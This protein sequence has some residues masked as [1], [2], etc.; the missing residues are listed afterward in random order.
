MI[1]R[2]LEA[3]PDSP[4]RKGLFNISTAAVAPLSG[5]ST[6][7]WKWWSTE[8]LSQLQRFG[9]WTMPTPNIQVGDVVCIR[10]EHLAPT[11]CP[12][13]HVVDVHP[14]QDG[15]VRVVTVRTSRGTYKCP[16]TKIV[17]LIHQ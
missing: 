6:A 8:D 13:A 17:T 16:V 15:Q 12:L 4:K 10:N 7:F 5:T 1:G 9:K 2:P 11:K 14:G 3:L